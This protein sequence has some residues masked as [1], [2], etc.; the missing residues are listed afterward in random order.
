MKFNQ[1]QKIVLWL[2]GIGVFFSLG[3][4]FILYPTIHNIFEKRELQRNNY[5]SQFPLLLGIPLEALGN[6]WKIVLIIL[7]FLL[8]L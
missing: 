2:L 6:D 7:Y 3:S 4:Y 1:Q 8:I 5:G